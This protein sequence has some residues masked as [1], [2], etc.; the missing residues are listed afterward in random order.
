M[1][2]CVRTKEGLH[3]TLA[4]TGNHI[5]KGAGVESSARPVQCR[6]TNTERF[7]EHSLR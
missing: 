1:E 2:L 7:S 6:E 4:F 3:K 5:R